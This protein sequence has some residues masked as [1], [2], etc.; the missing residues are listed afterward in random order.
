MLEDVAIVT[1]VWFVTLIV[2][3]VFLWSLIQLDERQEL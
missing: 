2:F 3:F 1:C